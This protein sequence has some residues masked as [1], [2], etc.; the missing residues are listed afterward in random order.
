MLSF[1]RT[2]SR[3]LGMGLLRTSGV[4][5]NRL[6]TGVGRLYSSIYKWGLAPSPKYECSATDQTADHV[7]ST[8]PLHRAPRGVA[9]LMALDDDTRCWLNTTTAS[10]WLRR[11]F[12]DVP[13]Y[14]KEQTYLTT[15]Q[16]FSLRCN[17]WQRDALSQQCCNSKAGL[18]TKMFLGF[19][20][21]DRRH[22]TQ[23]SINS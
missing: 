13:P 23:F 14:E 15:R 4:K 18:D 11:F 20:R 6:R 16:F 12:L 2:S 7:I 17:A 5:L 22:I 8:C 10:I 9:G 3:P 1:P 21:Q 19:S